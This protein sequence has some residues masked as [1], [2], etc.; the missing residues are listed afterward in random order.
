[1]KKALPRIIVAIGGIL[2]LALIGWA[3]FTQSWLQGVAR[4]SYDAPFRLRGHIAAPEM[5]LV[6]MDE[7]SAIYLKQ[8]DPWDRS[9]HTR[10][11][12]RLREDGARAVFFDVVFTGNSEDPA[13]DA[14]LGAEMKAHGNVFIGGGLD[15]SEESGQAQEMIIAPTP[16]LRRAVA[17]WGLLVFKPIDVDYGVRQIYPGNEQK[18][19]AT[20]VA[21]KKLGAPLPED[22]EERFQ[23]RYLNY[24]GPAGWLPNVS[25]LQ[26]IK[27]GDLPPGFF[28]DKIVFV[29]GRATMGP[30]RLGKDEFRTPYARFR[31]GARH[32]EEAR[33]A[34][35]VE[36]HATALLN[37]LRSEFLTRM[38]ERLEMAL[39]V[40]LGVL[41]GL[42]FSILRPVYSIVT[43]IVAAVIVA[44]G[45]FWLMFWGQ[46]IWFAWFVPVG[47]QIPIG[48]AWSQ[49][50]NYFLES[51]RRTALRR[52]FGH[53]LSPHMADRIAN[54]DV[55]LRPGGK[56]V[57]ATVMFT[58]L[59]GFTAMSESLG[60]PEKLSQVLTDYFTQTTR[61]VLENDGT[62]VK[63]IGDAVLAVWGAPMDD[64]QHPVKAA[65]AALAL[66][67]GATV[68]VDGEKL[69]TRIG[70]HTG[71]VVSGNL[72][73]A[74]RFDYT[75][76]GDP[77]NFASR[78]E[79]LNK[80]LGTNVLISDE[81][82]SR[83]G[84]EFY[85]RCLGQFTVVGRRGSV[86]IHELLPDQ[87]TASA[88]WVKIFGDALEAF[89][90]GNL[91]IAH[92][93]F[94]DV[95]SLRGKDGPSAYYLRYIAEQDGIAGPGWTG[96][97][98]V[99]TK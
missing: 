32:G 20:W 52:A 15:Y 13:I 4:F 11:I 92:R 77:V 22:E 34:P 24:Y 27:D 29:G 97:V 83:L 18:E 14:A 93:L 95:I 98:A 67:A 33:F 44:A 36:I 12:R 80:Y 8:G 69:R 28:K 35:G 46:H 1:V 56:A 25:Y 2:L 91:D 39:M 51:R 61:H 57:E 23:A 55:D 21:A 3:A 40:G 71:K 9:L 94:Q 41:F 72:G 7:K 50:A 43:A 79:G 99:A 53:Y 96:V 90:Q 10:L 26:A 87:G 89:T 19:G 86:V 17:G 47:L 38:P 81:T 16:S 5:C 42:L 85:S 74:Q 78:L 65:R 88:E 60:D 59:E 64:A 82:L 70:I 73:S 37:L 66:H 58:D 48:L 84:P 75:V 31:G 45:A 63:F 68:M 6:Y 76:I 54:S 49:T 62:I 30:L